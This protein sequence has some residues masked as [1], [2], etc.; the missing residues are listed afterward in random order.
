MCELIHELC[1]RLL[2]TL[3][4]YYKLL[5]LTCY[6]VDCG[7][8]KSTKFF[9]SNGRNALSIVGCFATRYSIK[10]SYDTTLRP[11][12]SRRLGNFWPNT[13]QGTIANGLLNLMA[14]STIES[15]ASSG[16]TPRRSDACVM[17]STCSARSRNVSV[18]KSAVTCG[19]SDSARGALGSP[20]CACVCFCLC[21]Y[22]CCCFVSF[23]GRCAQGASLCESK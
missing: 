13:Q 23:I 7:R 1:I 18:L 2:V 3:E 15:V 8:R 22:L 10:S 12:A 9:P 21:K 14:T 4:L 19:T 16:C 11:S 17:S 6:P 5:S 20:C